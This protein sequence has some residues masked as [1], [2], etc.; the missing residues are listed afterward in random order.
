MY[1]FFMLPPDRF[2]T[3][4]SKILDGRTSTGRYGIRTSLVRT[5]HLYDSQ[6]RLMNNGLIKV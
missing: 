2:G 6:L 4:L 3:V 5:W 1:I